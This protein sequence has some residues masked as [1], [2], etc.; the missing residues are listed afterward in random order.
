MSACDEFRARLAALLSTPGDGPAGPEWSALTWHEHLHG[1]GECRDLLE[2]EEALEVL[3]ETL[4]EPRLPRALCDRVLQRLAVARRSSSGEL[5]LD[6]LL[7]LA[8]VA[9]PGD[10]ADTVLQGLSRPRRVER[11]ERALDRLLD[12][13]PETE[14]PEG[15]AGRVLA[16]LAARRGETIGLA[17]RVGGEGGGERSLRP[18]GS[19]P[20]NPWRS[21]AFRWAVAA[22]LLLSSAVV[23]WRA[24]GSGESSEPGR[25]DLARGPE[26]RTQPPVD[27]VVAS[28]EAPPDELLASLD[29]LESWEFLTGEDV[30]EVLAS[31]DTLDELV[32]FLDDEELGG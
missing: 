20:R 25:I 7:G 14:T 21:P 10:L 18:M 19:A 6:R 26:A 22:G 29:L 16:G 23:L 28:A 5:E 3:L 24:S 4:P 31:M 32:L 15:L 30:D 11:E 27:E 8:E 2:A 13:L 17:G 1:C 9:L 12:R